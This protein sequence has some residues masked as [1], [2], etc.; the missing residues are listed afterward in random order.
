L[1]LPLAAQADLPKPSFSPWQN[2]S[3]SLFSLDRLTMDHSLGFSAGTSSAGTGYY[4]SRYTNHLRYQF[5]P[6]LDLELNLNFVNYG[7]TGSRFSLN[8]DN[9]SRIIPEFRLSWK[10]SSSVQVQVQWQQGNPFYTDL[11]PWYERW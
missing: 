11:R 4:L 1:A 10:P 2:N 5:N 6:K 7:S 8:D 3:A 9:R